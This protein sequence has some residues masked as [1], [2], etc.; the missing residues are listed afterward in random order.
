M[1]EMV[2]LAEIKGMIWRSLPSSL[3][4]SEEMFLAGLEEWDISPLEIDGDLVA[5]AI[6]KG[7]EFHFVTFGKPWKLTRA[8]L[9]GYLM[10]LVE[11]Y[12]CV[13]TKTPKEDTR[14]RRFNELIGFVPEGE[15]EYF[16]QYRATQLRHV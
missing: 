1:A 14:Q 9:R 10:P 4:I 13:Q 5:A 8:Q 7:P 3:Y 11:K 15:D 6:T 12:G 2:A 16:V